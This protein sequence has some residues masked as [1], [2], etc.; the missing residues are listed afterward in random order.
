MKRCRADFRGG[1]LFNTARWLGQQL[2]Q[3]QHENKIAM[4]NQVHDS[5]GWRRECKCKQISLVVV[6]S[7][8]AYAGALRRK[9]EGEHMQ[10]KFFSRSP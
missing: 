7:T 9:T 6:Q 3:K 10:Q 8:P 4:Q 1:K 2:G 5:G